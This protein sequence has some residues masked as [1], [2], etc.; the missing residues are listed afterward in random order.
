MTANAPYNADPRIWGPHVWATIHTTALKADAA[1]EPEAFVGLLE[2]L[3][4]ILPC[5]TCLHD[6]VKQYKSLGPPQPGKAFA[7]TVDLHNA[8]NRKLRHSEVSYA[9]AHARWTASNCS[10]LCTEPPKSGS[11][12]SFQLAL[13][14]CLAIIFLAWRHAVRV[15]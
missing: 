8:V 2:A 11:W 9:E 7:W 10:F 13:L 3:T 12:F 15:K 1:G 6:Y 14:V 4:K 5:E